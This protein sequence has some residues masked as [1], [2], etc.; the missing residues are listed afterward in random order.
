MGRIL[1]DMSSK[2][3]FNI[4]SINGGSKNNAIPREMDALIAIKS[5]DLKRLKK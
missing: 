4:Q 5:S 2:I 3:D 1:K